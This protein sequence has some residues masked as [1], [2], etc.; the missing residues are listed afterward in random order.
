MS[1]FNEHSRFDWQDTFMAIP[2]ICCHGD[3]GLEFPEIDPTEVIL[4]VYK[5]YQK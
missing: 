5:M 2:L 4:P 3:E 1:E